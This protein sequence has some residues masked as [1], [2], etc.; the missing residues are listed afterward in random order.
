MN[1]YSPIAERT[2]IWATR[3]AREP[4]SSASRAGRPNSLT[5]VAPGAEKRSVIW[6]VIAALWPAPSRSSCASRP[7]IRRAGI[8][9]SGSS[10]NASSVICHDNRN[11][12]ASASTSEI[13]FETTPD[14]VH[15][16]ARWAPITSLFKR[17]TNAP[18]RVRMKNA[19][20]IRCTWVNTVRRR[21][22][23]RPSPI[24]AD[25]HRSQI[26]ITA[27]NTATKAIA[28]ASH[29]IVR[30]EPSLTIWSTT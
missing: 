2:P 3:S 4:N 20:G 8:T 25:C 17:L 30:S 18:V 6:V 28:I 21:S 9:N 7:P 23:M 5:S 1:T 15:V 14:N 19:T 22:R 29:T 24:R 12:T 27:W 10:N 26:E 11:I 16:N 13:T